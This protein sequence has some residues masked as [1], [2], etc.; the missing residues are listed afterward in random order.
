MST[1]NSELSG[2]PISHFYNPYLT[3]GRNRRFEL[4]RTSTE[5]EWRSALTCLHDLYD[6][7]HR[8][9][10]HPHQLRR[11]RDEVVSYL[12]PHPALAF[13]M[14]FSMGFVQS[15]LKKKNAPAL[16]TQFSKELLAVDLS[17]RCPGFE[18]FI[19]PNEKDP[20]YVRPHLSMT[21][22]GLIVSAG[23]ER[24]FFD[25]ALSDPTKCEGLVVRD[26]NPQVKAYVDFNVLLLRIAT[27]R[28]DYVRLSTLND[29][30]DKSEFEARIQEIIALTKASKL[31]PEI[32][33]YYLKHLQAFG[34]I[35]FHARERDDWRKQTNSFKG[36]KYHEDDELFNQLQ[37]YARSG[38][39]IA[40]FGDIA[41]LQFLD[42]RNVAILDISNIQDYC[43]LKFK[44]KSNPTIISIHFLE[45]PSKFYCS[46]MYRNLTSQEC[47]EL[48]SLIEFFIQMHKKKLDYCLHIMYY[49]LKSISSVKENSSK[50]IDPSWEYYSSG[51]LEALQKHKEQYCIQIEDKWLDF[52]PQGNLN[53][54]ISLSNSERDI[55]KQLWIS[56]QLKFG[57]S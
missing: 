18:S 37:R 42:H 38:N 57:L 47:T 4:L 53:D 3:D 5:Q 10:S 34:E 33:E 17:H 24:S 31:A 52:S 46:S 27:H 43:L 50:T 8:I 12:T 16:E 41:D 29:I 2:I 40:T 23:T 55:V 13:R 48:D 36:V 49:I 11:L 32:E 14:V 19:V 7:A 30:D 28:N 54:G 25:L 39:I 56:K 21:R 22:P 20:L 26:I 35:Y 9:Q 15:T 1:K 45:V 51:L 44:T 6:A